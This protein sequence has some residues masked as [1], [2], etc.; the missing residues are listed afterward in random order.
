[1]II[2]ML[3]NLFFKFFIVAKD[4]FHFFIY[5][6]NIIFLPSVKEEKRFVLLY[7]CIDVCT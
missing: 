1:M 7:T 6:T 3:L 5:L 2:E 4:F